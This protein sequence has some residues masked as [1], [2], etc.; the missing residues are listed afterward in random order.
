MTRL[1]SVGRCLWV[2][3]Y[4]SLNSPSNLTR[5]PTPWLAIHRR[6]NRSQTTTRDRR[7]S[8]GSVRLAGLLVDHS[9]IPICQLRNL[10]HQPGNA[11]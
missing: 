11:K 2:I 9:L 5:L 10:R 8:V 6:G 4:H 3:Y 1:E 7:T